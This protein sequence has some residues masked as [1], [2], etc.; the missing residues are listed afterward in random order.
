MP[1][2]GWDN[3][4]GAAGRD[5]RRKQQ[6]RKGRDTPVSME[7]SQVLSGDGLRTV[8]TKN[9]DSWIMDTLQP[10]TAFS[11]QVK[12]TVGRI[13]EFLKTTC[14]GGKIRVQKTVKGGSTGKGTALKKNSDAD[15]VLF[16][17]CF[18]SYEDQKMN[19]K[20][21]LDLIKERLKACRE[22]L[23][24]DVFISE[25]RYK[26]PDNMP[27]SLSL[28]LS[29]KE[30]E[31]ES[32]D[33]DI[34]PAYDA[35]GQV[36]QDAP[37]NPEVY[38]RLLYASRH[39]GEFSPCFTELQKM[40][41][42]RCPAKLKNLLRLVKHW[43]KELLNPQYP[44][45]DLPPKYALEL[46][47]IYAWEEGTES[48]DYFDTAQGFRTVL[49]LLCRHR[50]ICIYWEKYY[51]LQHRE[52]GAHVKGLLRRSRPV[53][54][55]PADPTGILGQ[56]KNW[57]VMA[58]AAASYCYSLPC[59]ANV[60]PWNVQPARPVTIEVV[61]LSGIKLTRC[62]SPYTTIRQLK[63]MIQQNWG[64]PT[65]T[66]RLAQQ[67]SGRSS[68][69]LQDCDTLA[70]HGIFYNTTLVLLQTEPQKMQVLV[71][72]DK[73][74]TTTYTVLPT[75]TVRQLKEQI[76][77]RQGPSA[78]EQRLT[79][80]SRELE[81]QHTLAHYDIKPMS[82]IFMLLRLRGGADPQLP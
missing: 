24:F 20:D 26:G 75:D 77:A 54:L 78:K 13:C 44:N 46:L 61:Q 1:R 16:L 39:P 48:C 60:Q 62:V 7:W 68:I 18:L 56:D 45:V 33:M 52:I 34:L 17:S 10:S 3:P 9:L 42:K 53:I 8:T 21:I 70:T 51:S 65:Y 74:R 64:I 73:N 2:F 81:D 36:T 25:P 32:T 41:V 50:E 71:K 76:Q 80:G 38:V 31:E 19:R 27:R 28:T 15:V 58:E 12:D 23:W 63:E 55:D 49:E 5:R 40:F 59:L 37:P 69:I 57:D 47:T 4:Q 43:Y 66:Q 82:T 29:S 35:L 11:K 79:Y 6:V 67:E 22:S 14:F 30:T 72:D